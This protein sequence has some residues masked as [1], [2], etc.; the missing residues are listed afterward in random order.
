MAHL[1]QWGVG[2][3]DTPRLVRITEACTFGRALVVMMSQRAGSERSMFHAK[4]SSAH[5]MDG[6]LKKTSSA[7][8]RSVTVA[9]SSAYPLRPELENAQTEGT[10]G[11]A[12]V[13]SSN[14]SVSLTHQM[15]KRS[16]TKSLISLHCDGWASLAIAFGRETGHH[17]AAKA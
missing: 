1:L 6:V 7:H 16:T 10:R 9:C 2:H 13:V 11:G 3:S 17:E 15:M 8:R 4:T 12:T 14:F 5:T